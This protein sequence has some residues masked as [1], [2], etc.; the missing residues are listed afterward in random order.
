MR[1]FA[2]LCVWMFVAVL[3]VPPLRAQEH[4]TPTWHEARERTYDVLHYRLNLE[5][6]EKAKTCAGTAAIT[7]TP[8][9]TQFDAVLLDAAEMNIATVT[10]RGKQ[11]EFTHPGDTL[12]VTLDKAYGLSDTLTLEVAYAVHS[13]RKGLYF[14]QPDS[15]YPLKQ[16]QVWSQ[17][18][19]EDNHYWFPC[20]DFPNDKATS[21]MI[22]TV[23]EPLVAVS[24]GR[25]VDTKH[26]ARRKMVTY[27]W[28]EDK[29]HVSYCISLVVGQYVEVKDAWGA[30][31]ISNFVYPHQRADAMRS[32]GKTPKMIDYFSRMTQFPYPWEKYG[33]VVI[34]DF[35]YAGQENVSISTLTD[36]TIHDSRAQLDQTSDNL[37]AHELAHQW[38]GDLVSF[39]DW[40]H[41]WLSEGFASYFDFLFQG[42]D[43]GDDE[44]DRLVHEAQ[45][46]VAAADVGDRRRPTVCSRFVSPSELFDNRIYGKGACV[47]H[48]MRFTLGDDLFWK[49]LRLYVRE[50]AYG[51]ATTEDLK[52]AV[53]EATGYNL[54]WFFDEWLYRAG[55]PEFSV[56][57]AWDQATRSVNVTVRQTQKCDSL[58][59]I[60]RMPV[61]IEVW[62]HGTPTTY[63]VEVDQAE[64]HF[65]FPAYQE[66]QLVLFDKGNHI[67]KKLNQ[68][69]P[70]SA[71]LFQL[72]HADLPVDRVRSIE[73]LRWIVDSAAV[74]EAM[75][76]ALLADRSWIVRREAAWALGDAR[77]ALSDSIV[78]GY[79]DADARVRA[80]AVT[81]MRNAPGETVLKTLRHA[82]EKDSSYAVAGAALR[83]LQVADTAHA[84]AYCLEALQRPSQNEAIR[85]AALNALSVF[86][87]EQSYDAIRSFSRYGIDRNLRVL[88]LTILAREWKERP[89]VLSLMI[90]M[91]ADPS[92]HVRRTA[93]DIL[94]NL[95]SPL[96]LP[97]LRDR[98]TVDAESR[99]VKAARDAI[100]KIEKAQH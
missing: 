45:T 63:R 79:G 67:L 86:H 48:M 75:M 60:F 90:S 30:V 25:L 39:R 76:T 87:D 73:E 36:G 8:L 62:V 16:W 10:L 58:T 44:L 2:P 24:N 28:R 54:G 100:D 6:D 59:G 96:A 4:A 40:S 57:T 14:V 46:S 21:E 97:V 7:L 15:G 5:I 3:S 98:T 29:P 85:N 49:S 91:A 68:Q 43:K 78:A 77:T 84:R 18:E 61:D 22:A 11:L 71:W 35:M 31:P 65:S 81:A 41:S 72:G 70:P 34:Q 53:E 17:G 83:S 94:G 80:A 37:V 69:Q 52:I 50:H 20:Y 56:S 88:S 9:R 12:A 95:G 89:D 51:S 55:Y 92:Y 64:Q 82:F 38:W 47:L 27:H 93:I 13:P 1:R 42:F 74:R 26:D 99:I 32:F 66:P 33:H 19:Q 23:R